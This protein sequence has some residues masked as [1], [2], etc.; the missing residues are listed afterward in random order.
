MTA[1]IVVLIIASVTLILTISSIVMVKRYQRGTR[2]LGHSG[3]PPPAGATV[4]NDWWISTKETLSS[5]LFAIFLAF[6]FL[7][8]VLYRTG[9]FPGMFKEWGLMHLLLYPLGML[10]FSLADQNAKGRRRTVA[11]GMVVVAFVIL[12]FSHVS[13]HLPS[14]LGGTTTVVLNDG[15]CTE[16]VRLATLK[17]NGEE[18]NKDGGCFA[19]VHEETKGECLDVYDRWNRYIGNDCSNDLF[20]AM[21]GARFAPSTRSSAKVISVTY[22]LCNKRGSTSLVADGCP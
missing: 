1:L 15:L 7:E 10:A 18:L 13:W 20:G 22:V 8:I 21:Y 2:G 4:Q 19:R 17:G 11:I 16:K 5:E 6:L 12:G 14:W 9:W 3:T